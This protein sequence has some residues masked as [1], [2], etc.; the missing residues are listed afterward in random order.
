MYEE[1]KIKVPNKDNPIKVNLDLLTPEQKIDLCWN[2]KLKGVSIT[3]LSKCFSVTRRTIYQ[4]LAKAKE[5]FI[6][7]MEELTYL[8]VIADHEMQLEHL[9]NVALAEL[10]RITESE[11]GM[12]DNGEI[13]TKKRAPTKEISD[14]IRTIAGIRDQRM[15]LHQHCGIIPKMPDRLHHVIS[16]KDSEALEEYQ[17]SAEELRLTL[18]EKLNRVSRL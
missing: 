18:V 17:Q 2:W 3:T 8:E 1:L 16:N 14:L 10:D 15:K 13:Y 12:D 7:N 9:E 5:H 11:F 4:W 6:S